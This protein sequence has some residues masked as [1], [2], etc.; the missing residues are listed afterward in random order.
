VVAVRGN[1]PVNCTRPEIHMS[2]NGGG[3]HGLMHHHLTQIFSL[4][5]VLYEV[6]GL[7]Y[8]RSRGATCGAVGR[9]DSRCMRWGRAFG[10]G[11]SAICYVVSLHGGFVN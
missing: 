1:V 11:H 6:N 5:V 8:L 10:K 7:G 3:L 4:K 2:D 9:R